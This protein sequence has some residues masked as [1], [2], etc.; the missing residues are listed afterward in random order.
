MIRRPPRSTLFPYTT[1]FRSAHAPGARA[2]RGAVPAAR[3]LRHLRFPPASR[4]A[5]RGPTVRGH[6]GTVRASRLDP[7]RPRIRAVVRPADGARRLPGYEPRRR[8]GGARPRQ[9]GAWRRRTRDPHISSRMDRAP[10][11][12]LTRTGHHGVP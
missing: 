2:Y 9:L 1:L 11:E 7:A 8:R 4:L 3:D 5:R 12:A 6:R 10:A